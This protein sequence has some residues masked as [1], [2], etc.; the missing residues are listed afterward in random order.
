LELEL[1][2]KTEIWVQPIRVLDVNLGLIAETFA[3]VLHLKKS[4]VMVV[5]VREDL[6]TVDILKRSVNAED[7][8]GKK[9]ALLQALA[10][11][12]G[13]SITSETG[14][15]SDGILGLI[16]IEDQ[17][18]AGEILGGMERMGREVSERIRQ[19]A[20]VFSSGFEVR[21]GMIQDTN[22]PYIKS[23]LTQE[24]FS[25]TVGDILEDDVASI[26]QVLRRALSEG[27][28][29]IITTG[30]VGA[31]DKDR[32]VEALLRI[33]PEASTPYI[34]HY[35]K[36]KGRH[37]K[38]GVKIGVAYIRPTFLIAL[39]GPHEEVKV[40]MEVILKGLKEGVGKEAL[41]SALS[42]EY[43]KRL[44]RIHHFPNG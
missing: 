21:R 44:R 15:H 14:V 5:D 26:V 7:I 1:F 39:P 31:E 38:D 34:I 30:G 16:D 4:E 3:E 42:E 24:G 27:Y 43:R 17:K 19:R 22:S 37:E 41:A 40:G 25:V 10:A 32:M 35:E 6:V 11:I 13:V 18:M 29:L 12:P 20:I 8:I 23:K 2:E 36:G 28:G 9:D 33:D